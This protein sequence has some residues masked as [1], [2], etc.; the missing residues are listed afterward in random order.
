MKLVFK[1][2]LFKQA[3]M[4][5]FC[6]LL[7]C[8]CL[9]QPRNKGEAEKAAYDFASRNV[10]LLDKTDLKLSLTSSLISSN[11]SLC[12]EK[13]A[14]YVFSSV[15]NREGFI[16]V[17]GD[18]RMPAIL[19]YSEENSFDVDNVPPNVR[20]WLDCYAESFLELS[21]DNVNSHVSLTSVNEAGVSPLLSNNSWSQDD[22]YNR[23]CPSIRNDKCVTG[24]VAT[25]MAQ[26]MNFHKHPVAGKG[27]VSY[28]TETNGILLQNDL[29][30]IY[31][32]WKDIL[33]N[34]S[35]EYSSTQADAVAEL[36]YACGTSVHMD[37][38]TSSQGGS[39]AYQTDLIPAYINNFDYDYDAAFMARSYCSLEDWHRILINELNEGRPVNYAGQSIRDGGHSFVFDGY[40]ISKDNKYPDY[41]VN[42][43]WNGSCNG[44]YQITDL[45][46]NVGGQNATI[47]GFNS[48][49][50]IAIGIKPNDGV[51]NGIFY[52]CTSDLHIS[53]AS[54]KPGNTIKVS[55]S[56][57]DNFSYKDF[58]G[59]LHVA[60]VSQE[61]DSE[62]I[63]GESRALT[64]GYLKEQSN[65]SIEITLPFNL[66]EGKYTIQ[67]R[68]KQDKSES[69]NHVYSSKYPELTISSTGNADS[70][71]SNE[72]LLGCSEIELI[73]TTDPTKI[74]LNLYELQNLLEDPFI[75][76]LRMVLADNSGNQLIIFGDSI[77]TGELSMFEIQNT[78]QKLEGKLTGNWTDGNYRLYVGARL[79]NTNDYVHLSYYDITQPSMTNQELFLSAQIKDNVLLING[80][81]YDILST[82]V[83]SVAS[84][85]PQN[86]N[87]YNLNGVKFNN[88]YITS[89][90]QKKGIY[91]LRQNKENR[92]KIIL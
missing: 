90:V 56:S 89:K 83:N 52:L 44:Y 7:P 82:S 13:E 30:T 71:I 53:S 14:Y 47:A 29:S 87:F 64:L 50:Q 86:I 59:T 76:D 10:N 85:S 26:V 22:P 4:F 55:S 20:Y 48:S 54:C 60:L 58:N 8:F 16:I 45:H 92:K 57:L 67:L 36:M 33:D 61:D 21:N 31:F 6:G 88:D 3:A 80:H 46:P 2:G 74:C 68:S 27:H 24:C 79:I 43:G 75:G 19:A 28:R 70:L 17:S 38:C 73:N 72:V 41:H 51:D 37:Y 25:A 77:Q 69:Y 65:I 32:K 9:A 12:S 39:G 66:S 42:W 78:P 1:N 34:Y 84:V 35:K 15:T 23:L 62:I 40:K 49:Q 91:I 11:E 81:T 18:K 63:L 5:T